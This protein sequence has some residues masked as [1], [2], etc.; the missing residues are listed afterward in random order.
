MTIPYVGQLASSHV[1][2]HGCVVA[3]DGKGREHVSGQTLFPRNAAKFGSSQYGTVMEFT[4]TNNT[5]GLWADADNWTKGVPG[6]WLDVPGAPDPAGNSRP[7][8]TA[9]D[10]Q[11]SPYA[12]MMTVAL[13]ASA[14]F[15]S[16]V[17]H[18][19]NVLIMG[20]GGYRF[21]DYIKAG[22]P[23]TL[24]MLAVVLFVL[25]IFWPF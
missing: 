11:M 24:V 9:A 1:L 17:A 16:P 23:L 22:L 21:T 5:D 12:L 6:A 14:S 2:K 3:I 10:L 8:T 25:P 13:A 19:S 15:L 7:L 4:N 20:P 18:P